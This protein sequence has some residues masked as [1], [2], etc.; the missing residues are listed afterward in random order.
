MDNRTDLSI[1]PGLFEI[2]VSF[3]KM[4]YWS[5]GLLETMSD[6]SLSVLVV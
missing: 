3:E 4:S 2:Y 5:L 6:M 1:G